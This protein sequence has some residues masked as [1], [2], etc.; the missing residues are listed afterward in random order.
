MSMKEQAI[1]IINEMDIAD[2]CD[3][4]LGYQIHKSGEVPC[5][6]FIRNKYTKLVKIGSTKNIKERYASLRGIFRNHFG[7]DDALEVVGII[8][9][10]GDKVSVVERF[11]HDEYRTQRRFGEWFDIDVTQL[12]E[13][14]LLG[15]AVCDTGIR[16][17]TWLPDEIVPLLNL[18]DRLITKCKKSE[19]G[20]CEII[21]YLNWTFND[22]SQFDK[23]LNTVNTIVEAI[24]NESMVCY[25]I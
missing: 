1:N 6:Y 7:V 24:S 23:R 16:I 19:N 20:F 4:V 18:K 22:E 10:D 17:T 25:M 5:V 2:I 8:C 9:A 21:E 11:F 12:E 14:W 15:D 3:S 13:D